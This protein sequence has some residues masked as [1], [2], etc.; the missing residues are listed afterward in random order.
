MKRIS[1]ALLLCLMASGKGLL[2]C[3]ADQ[4]CRL[5]AADL[6]RRVTFLTDMHRGEPRHH[7]AKVTVER[8]AFYVG[9]EMSCAM[10]G[11]GDCNCMLL[12]NRGIVQTT[13]APT[14]VPTPA[15]VAPKKKP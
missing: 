14:P 8:C 1:V 5:Q 7:G 6:N 3:A 9:P 10:D 15:P 11:E 2:G 4:I 13:A 12:D